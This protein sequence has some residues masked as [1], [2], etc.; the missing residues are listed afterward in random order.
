MIILQNIFFPSNIYIFYLKNLESVNFKD[1]IHNIN[2]N[3]YMLFAWLQAS[4]TWV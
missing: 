2:V 1:P 4:S 3:S